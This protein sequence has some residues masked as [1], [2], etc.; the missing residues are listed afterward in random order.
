MADLNARLK[1]KKSSTASETPQASDLLI[2]EL[3]VNTADGILYTKHTDNSIV[4]IAGGG[5]GGAVNSV[6][7]QTG[8]VVLDVQDL[9][10]TYAL[11][12]PFGQDVTLIL[13]GEGVN[14]GTTFTDESVNGFTPTFGGGPATPVTSTTEFK[15]GSSSIY[16]P[17]STYMLY[18][19]DTAWH[20]RSG[21]FTIET[22]FYKPTGSNGG[23]AIGHRGGATVNNGWALLHDQG[24]TRFV[25][26]WSLDGTTE[27]S[28]DGTF[29]PITGVWYHVAMV[30]SGTTGTI[31]VN[32]SSIATGTITGTIYNPPSSFVVGALA[33]NSGYFYQ[34]EI[35]LDE[36]R[37]TKAARYTAN[38][39]PAAIELPG[40]Y[41]ADGQVLTWDNANNL[42]GPA[43]VPVSGL[44]NVSSYTEVLG[45]YATRATFNS[46]PPTDQ[47]SANSTPSI[48][49]PPLAGNGL[50]LGTK[51]GS[52]NPGTIGVSDDGKNFTYYVCSLW[53]NFTSYYR[54]TLT[55]F[56][57]EAF[58]YIGDRP[59]W[60]DFGPEPT[61]AEGSTLVYEAT[62]TH[63][64]IKKNSIVNQNDFDY[65]REVAVYEFDFDTTDTPSPASG[66]ATVWSS[67]GDQYLQL[68]T[69]DKNS[70]NAE[71]DL[72]ALDGA[73]P[74]NLVV[75]SV[76]GVVVFDGT[77][78]STLNENS[79]RITLNFGSVQSWI[80]DLQLNDVVG[81]KSDTVFSLQAAAIAVEDGQVLAWVDSDSQWKPA[82]IDGGS[83]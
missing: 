8:T 82:T 81:I 57:A 11:G 44:S 53:E 2:G 14:N 56:D 55:G 78:T 43:G 69:T 60:V 10:D 61:P 59:I 27:S 5:G 62:D 46:Q 34:D 12:D 6:N 13:R 58:Y 75:M 64:K 40:T 9:D 80:T 16:Q 47:W 71:T 49:F 41:P 77:I 15:Y 39:T 24:N 18:A 72:Y 65:Q 52:E 76:N 28:F 25:F 32:G 37:L 1:P 50:N 67:Y 33:Q 21:D 36:V 26:Y 42:W 22:W 54:A 7:G 23:F 4:T 63:Y 20:V 79:S 30:R 83:F 48:L 73:A 29:S 17:D 31:Y 35:Y 38:F 3:A 51:F 19:D 68:S 66:K 74:N 70:L 45:T